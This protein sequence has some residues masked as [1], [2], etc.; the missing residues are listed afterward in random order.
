MAARSIA[1]PASKE[2]VP[3]GG[4]PSNAPRSA[5]SAKR[6][7]RGDIARGDLLPGRQD[8]EPWARLEG[9]GAETR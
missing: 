2:A 7:V 4:L 5:T 8:G 1:R 6:T 9:V 3:S